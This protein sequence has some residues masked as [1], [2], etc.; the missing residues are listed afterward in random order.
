MAETTIRNC[1]QIM[2]TMSF[3][4]KNKTVIR[5]SSLK[6]KVYLMRGNLILFWKLKRE[7]LLILRQDNMSLFI[8]IIL[9]IRMVLVFTFKIQIIA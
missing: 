6:K 1:L 2:H 5:K 9:K 8:I 4:L 3:N 7:Y